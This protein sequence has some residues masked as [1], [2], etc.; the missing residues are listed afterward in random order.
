MAKKRNT[1][2]YS[3][4]S[5][6]PEERIE[7][8]SKKQTLKESESGLTTE[9][10]RGLAAVILFL[11]ALL[12]LLTF[13]GWVGAV[14]EW[15]DYSLKLIFGW[16]RI[17]VPLGF[18]LAGVVSLRPMKLSGG[19]SGYFGVGLLVLA[20]LGLMH[21][22][23]PYAEGFIEAQAGS[24][25]G[26]IGFLISYPLLRAFS[27]LGAWIIFIA[28][29]IIGILIFA[30]RPL[31]EL[32]RLG[33]KEED[34]K[35]EAVKEVDG[36][37]EDPEEKEKK[38]FSLRTKKLPDLLNK[39]KE[40]IE[41]KD[42]GEIEPVADIAPALSTQHKDYEAPSIDLLE[43]KTDKPT[44]G[45]VQANARIIKETLANFGIEVEMA[46]AHIGPT[47]TQYTLRPIEG[48][49]LSKITALQNDIAL[50]LAAHP[51][52]IEAPIPGKSL[53]GIE[54][55]NESVA[56]VRFRDIVGSKDFQGSTS[57][58]PIAIGRDVAGKPYTSELDKMP[59]ML[60]AGA[61]GSGKSVAINAMLLSLVYRNGP[62]D[63]KM[64]LVDPKRVELSAYN[65]IP[66]LL[67]PVITEPQKTVNALKW[68][69]Q[70]M[71][72]RY[73]IMSEAGARN[74]A[75]YN[76]VTKDKQLPYIIIVID[77]LAD[78]MSVAAKDVEALIV[79]LAQLARATGIHLILATQRPSVDVI[80]GLIKA[81]ITTRMAFS[82]A[83]GTDSRTILDF[84]GAE[85]LLGRG[86]M[87]FVSGELSKP[88]RL[89]GA[90][91]TD[92]EVVKVTN[93]LKE[94]GEPHYN[95]DVVSPRRD[96]MGAARGTRAAGGPESED[97]LY[98]D[99]KQIFVESGK[100]SASLLQR[101]LKIG[102]ARAARLLDMLEEAGV[103]GP[104]D[105]AKP[106][107]VLIGAEPFPGGEFVAKDSD[108]DMIEPTDDMPL[109][110]GF[111]EKSSDGS[112]K[113]SDQ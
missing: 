69:T 71:D 51:I 108:S 99:A 2:Q 54:V 18:V 1:K 38:P 92:D 40:T 78:V 65:N 55:P 10:K 63:L 97:P 105:G 73:K 42:G 89:Q 56:M 29:F 98:N 28:I 26:W 61:T 86:D 6:T 52:R 15:I 91:V 67:T 77:E 39:K 64:I 31:R 79:R 83:S 58:L 76:R 8:S 59:H 33:R 68:A 3:I 16:G 72:K 113:D 62:T 110:G 9:T 87:L 11:L 36:S 5:K 75:A 90:F 106:R 7:E 107:E 84:S 30:N 80:T 35:E 12:T 45:D 46:D 17:L 88:K 96:G 104:S 53:V 57:P 85:K 22:F 100:G 60:I 4:A 23:F 21:S 44:S 14:G 70:E 103:I 109:P 93:H 50:A 49:K 20:I 24:G 41:I 34:K 111:E 13:F 25:G 32:L 37:D 95:P 66:H 47:V 81:N 43:S 27:A 101:R 74:I 112:H 102:Y 19:K 94:I 48:T 82:V